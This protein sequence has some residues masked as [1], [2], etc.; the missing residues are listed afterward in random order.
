MIA[1]TVIVRVGAEAKFVANTIKE[2]VVHP[3]STS[4][5]DKRTGKVLSRNSSNG[6]KP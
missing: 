6:S 4:V 5:I 2:A 3:L 1:K